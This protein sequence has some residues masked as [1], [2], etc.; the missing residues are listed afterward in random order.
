MNDKS[1]NTTI[2]TA[3]YTLAYQRMA[4]FDKVFDELANKYDHFAMEADKGTVG[5]YELQDRLVSTGKFHK[6]DGIAIIDEMTRLE[7]IE[8]VMTDT[9]RRKYKENDS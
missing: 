7:K 9:Y 8:I 3:D 2:T 1:N 6:S 5:R 4:I